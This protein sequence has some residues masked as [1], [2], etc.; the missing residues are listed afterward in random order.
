MYPQGQQRPGILQRL[1]TFLLSA[2]ATAGRHVDQE[3]EKL[4]HLRENTSFEELHL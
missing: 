2:A 1:A 4:Q 3:S